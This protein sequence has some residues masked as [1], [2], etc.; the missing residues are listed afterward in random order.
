MKSTDLI[1]YVNQSLFRVGLN[2]SK[3]DVGTTLSLQIMNMLSV[4]PHNMFEF[5][6]VVLG[7]HNG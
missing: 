3:D 6:F 5:S 4:L 7:F 2:V 1:H